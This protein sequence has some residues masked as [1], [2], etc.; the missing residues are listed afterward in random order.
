MR[1]DPNANQFVNQGY[2]DIDFSQPLTHPSMRPYMQKTQQQQPA[3]PTQQGTRII[4][5]QVEGLQPQSHT[6][7][8]QR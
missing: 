3:L 5:I 2:N 6:V 7:I 4:P 1:T 8:L